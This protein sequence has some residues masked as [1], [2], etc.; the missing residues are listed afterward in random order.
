MGAKRVTVH[1]VDIEDKPG[2]LH[3]FLSQSSLSGVDYLCF[4]AFSCGN[5]HGRVA[6]SAKN[7]KTFEAF[8]KEAKLKAPEAA[9]F[10]VE[11][12]DRPGA[13]AKI[14][15]KLAEKDIGGIVGTAMVFNGRYQMLIVVD[16]KNAERAQKLLSG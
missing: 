7:P 9:G 12:E 10:I 13:A 8:V 14:I 11:G 3:R 1:C 15:A 4:V 2:S 16:A 5:N 6:V